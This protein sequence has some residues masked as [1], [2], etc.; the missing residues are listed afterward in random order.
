MDLIDGLS[1]SHHNNCLLVI[2][3]K[4]MKYVHFLP[5]YHPYTVTKVVELF[6]DNIYKLHGMSVALVSDHDPIDSRPSSGSLSSV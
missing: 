2:I 1:S 5:L 3:D 6:I 4:L